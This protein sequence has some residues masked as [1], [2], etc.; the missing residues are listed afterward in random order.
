VE[1][2]E[3]ESGGGDQDVEVEE[4]EDEGGGGDQDV[5]E[6]GRNGYKAREVKMEGI[7]VMDMWSA[8]WL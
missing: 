5:E 3:D 6:V 8:V 7:G 1:E 4:R 2:Q